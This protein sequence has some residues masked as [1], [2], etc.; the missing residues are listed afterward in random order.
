MLPARI[1]V[2]D[3]HQE[4]LRWA[5]E[6][7]ANSLEQ[8]LMSLSPI[9]FREFDSHFMNAMGP[10]GPWAQRAHS[11]PWP[12]LIKTGKLQLAAGTEHAS[13]NIS[14]FQ[15]G[16]AEFG[17]DQSVVNYAGFHEY[18]TSLMPARP[19]CWLSPEAEDEA[20]ERFAAALYALFAG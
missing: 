12:I 4:L 18:G 3:L 20:A 9:V 2:E 5:D 14:R 7:E 13:G 11:Y 16:W 6:I 1:E 8:P 17:L 15:N 10:N 19:W